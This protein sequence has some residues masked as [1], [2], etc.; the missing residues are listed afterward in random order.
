MKPPV[1]LR[2]DSPGW[3]ALIQSKGVGARCLVAA[4]RDHERRAGKPEIG[5]AGR[6][7]YYDDGSEVIFR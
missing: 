2:A 5:D 4:L 7:V 1:L 6:R 3:R